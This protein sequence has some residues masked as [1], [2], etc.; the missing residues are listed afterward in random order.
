MAL[1]IAI[2][3]YEPKWN[4]EKKQCI[5]RNNSELKSK[6]GDLSQI[7]CCSRVFPT[8]VSLLN[9]FKTKKHQLGCLRLMTDQFNRELPTDQ[10]PDEII[11]IQC[12]EIR[13]LKADYSRKFTENEKLQ[14]QLEAQT[15][16]IDNQLSKLMKLEV[17][18]KEERERNIIEECSPIKIM[19]R[20]KKKVVIKTNS[21]LLYFTSIA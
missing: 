18:L 1:E 21:N 13:K 14:L 8:R 2:Q 6:Y 3:R 16:K 9:H 10:S 17:E 4:L 20:P 11:V 15:V 5:D 19:I 12:K 7:L